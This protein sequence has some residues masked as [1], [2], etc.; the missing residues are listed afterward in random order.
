MR[1]LL[2]IVFIGLCTSFF[3]AAE[4]EFTYQGELNENGQVTNGLFDFEFMLWDAL[5]GG[6]QVGP[7]IVINDVQVFGGRFTVELDYGADA[8]DNSGRWLEIVVE[9]ATL[10]P[11]QPVTRSPYSIQTRGI[12]VDANHNVGIGTNT[13][14]FPLHVESNDSISI[15]GLAID[16]TSNTTGVAGISESPNGR[17]VYGVGN[18]GVWGFSYGKT[19]GPASYGAGS[20]SIIGTT[21]GGR[22]VSSSTSGPGVYGEA[23]AGTGFTVAGGSR[24]T[25]HP[26]PVYAA[27]LPPAP[28]TP[29][30]C[31]AQRIA[32]RDR[33]CR[34]CYAASTGN[35]FGVHGE[36]FSTSGCGVLG[37]AAA[38]SGTTY[39]GRFENDS[40]TGHGVIG[41]ANASSGITYGGWFQSDSTVGRGVFGLAQA[42]SGVNYGVVG[43]SNSSSGY[44]FWASGAGTNYGSSSSRRWK[45]NVESIG[46]PLVKLANSRGVLRLGH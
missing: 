30:A 13:P 45:S 7:P 24:A 40:T 38:N 17:G 35:T 42:N 27:R 12:F 31:T 20:T 9:G 39:G 22:F 19:S 34:Q 26:G 18:T 41:K 4:T 5:A 15:Y 1:Y 33:R 37:R 32:P 21:Y 16:S 36:S 43:H 6:N 28:A 11:R 46:D 10:S 2:T 14:S 44:D 29:V 8:F 23:T 25:A 3:A